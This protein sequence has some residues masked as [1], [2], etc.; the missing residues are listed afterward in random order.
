MGTNHG[1]VGQGE[2]LLFLKASFVDKC[3]PR[4]L[5]YG[6]GDIEWFLG[7]L[8]EEPKIQKEAK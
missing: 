7:L 6:I 3:W 8:K 4:F 1:R 5:F 2:E